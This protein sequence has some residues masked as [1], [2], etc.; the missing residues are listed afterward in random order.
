[1]HHDS[2][3]A[4]HEDAGYTSGTDLLSCVC[5]Q[6]LLDTPKQRAT[7]MSLRMPFYRKVYDALRESMESPN[8]TLRGVCLLCCLHLCRHLGHHAA[9]NGM[10]DVTLLSPP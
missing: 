1:M 7:I 9:G 2:L 6:V 3:V 8:G 4:S 10:P 5:R